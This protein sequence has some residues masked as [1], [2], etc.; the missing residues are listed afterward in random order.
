MALPRGRAKPYVSE[1]ATNDRARGVTVLLD[2][3]T[4][5]PTETNTKDC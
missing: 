4:G 2:A 3:M 5:E 1:V